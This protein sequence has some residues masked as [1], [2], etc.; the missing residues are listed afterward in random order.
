MIGKVFVGILAIFLLLGAFATPINDG[1]KTWRTQD[2][3][4]DFVV[5][6]GGGETTAN[7]TLAAD[8]FQ[9]STA[10][11]QSITSTLGGESPAASTYTEAT[12]VLL[13][14]G[15]TESQSRTLT[16]EYY[17]EPE[18]AVMSAIGP[19]LAVLIFFGLIG[20][21]IWGIFRK[22]GGRR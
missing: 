17:A 12:N 5:T 9:A 10:E 1:I 8:L 16:I 22:A 15:L 18:N 19:F 11:V 21:I 2:L 14:A 7:V 20:G 4:E 13:V 6:T 3:S